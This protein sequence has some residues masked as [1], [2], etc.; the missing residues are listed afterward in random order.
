MY[1]PADHVTRGQM[2]A[3]LA[4]AQDLSPSGA[5][6]FIDDDNSIFEDNINAV[7]DAGITN[8]C[9]ADMYCPANHVTRGQMA[10]FL[11]RSLDLEP[12]GVDHF[13]DDDG[14]IFEDDINAVADAGIT[15]GCTTD[16]Y[17]PNAN[18]T[19]GQMAAFLAR[20]F[21]DMP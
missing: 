8:G 7:A 17:C 20:A 19:R 1:C 2:A 21:L 4:R 12:S 16:R 18:V 11:A 15:L 10:A 9:T 3:F 6:H 14:S 5:D 13:M